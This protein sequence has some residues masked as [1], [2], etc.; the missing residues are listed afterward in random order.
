MRGVGARGTAGTAAAQPIFN[1]AKP[2][3]KSSK[4]LNPKRGTT[5][6]HQHKAMK[7]ISDTDPA[8]F[9]STYALIVRS[10]EKQRSR[11]EIFIYALLVA[12]TIFAIS[13]F[14]REAAAVPINLARASTIAPPRSA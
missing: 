7:T 11:F 13:Q 3:I 8:A 12:S 9:E 2:R 5:A 4:D 6:S 1:R 14:G 10:E